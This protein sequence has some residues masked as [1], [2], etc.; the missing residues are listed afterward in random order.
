MRY[1]ILG[2]FADSHSLLAAT[3][4][5]RLAGYKD[6]DTYSPYPLHGGS[7]ALGLPRS[8]VPLI[9]FAAALTGM[10]TAYLMQWYMNAYDYPLNVGNRYPHSMPAMI[11]VTFELTVLFSAFGAFFGT[12][13]L[14]KFPQPYHPAYEVEAF[15]SA[16]V[17]GFWLSVCLNDAEAA[18]KAKLELE[19]LG[20]KSTH[21]VEEP[22]R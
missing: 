7:E 12:L 17:D 18:A 20:P 4:K 5:L 6:L 13:A 10:A 14:A 22:T 16:T 8:K 11:P 21:L 1:W 9:V 19:G 2:E 15:R 3:E